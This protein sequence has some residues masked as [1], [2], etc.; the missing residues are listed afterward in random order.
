MVANLWTSG[1]EGL[2]SSPRRITKPRRDPKQPRM[3]EQQHQRLAYID[4]LASKNSRE[5]FSFFDAQFATAGLAE[6]LCSP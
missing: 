4:I 6:I 5:S 3:G 1:A 2:D